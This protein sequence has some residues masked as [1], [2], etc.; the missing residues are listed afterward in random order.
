MDGDIHRTTGHGT[1]TDRFQT[2]AV[3]HFCSNDDKFKQKTFGSSISVI[4]NEQKYIRI[5]CMHTDD[6][7]TMNF[8]L[9]NIH[10]FVYA[11][12]NRRIIVNITKWLCWH[13]SLSMVYNTMV[14][15]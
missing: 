10:I 13:S 8:R 11:Y 3:V 7:F 6:L 12:M 1:L 9:Y 4:I 15:K 5:F 14:S 2:N